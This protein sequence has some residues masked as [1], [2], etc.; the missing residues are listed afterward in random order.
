VLMDAVAD[1][2]TNSVLAKQAPPTTE[3]PGRT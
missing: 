3:S 2:L 1:E